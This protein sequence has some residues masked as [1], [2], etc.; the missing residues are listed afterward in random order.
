MKEVNEW[1]T[2]AKELGSKGHQEV[3]EKAAAQFSEL[4][5]RNVDMKLYF[6]VFRFGFDFFY[7]TIE[8][9][10]EFAQI[11]HRNGVMLRWQKGK[12]DSK[13]GE[14]TWPVRDPDTGDYVIPIVTDYEKIPPPSGSTPT[15]QYLGELIRFSAYD[16]ENRKILEA[17]APYAQ[18]LADYHPST[19]ERICDC[20]YDFPK[21]EYEKREEDCTIQ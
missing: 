20:I 10:D 19:Y 8:G 17:L 4:N 9:A 14:Y 11:S 12:R 6:R 18:Q 5:L 1:W 16:S 7:G 21:V 15:E 3:M 13:E 2:K